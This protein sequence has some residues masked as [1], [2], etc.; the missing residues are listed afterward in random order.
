MSNNLLPSKAAFWGHANGKLA[1][2]YCPSHCCQQL[3]LAFKGE[4]CEPQGAGAGAGAG[5]LPGLLR[6][7][8]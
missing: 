7:A 6:S 1:L 3:T 8:L 5:A 2:L 4:V